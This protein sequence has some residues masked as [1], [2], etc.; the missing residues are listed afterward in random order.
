MSVIHYMGYCLVAVSLIPL[1]EGVCSIESLLDIIKMRQ[2]S[3]LNRE[4]TIYR[5][6]PSISYLCKLQS[7]FS[8]TIYFPLI[9]HIK[10]FF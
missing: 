3:I 6:H 4:I 10:V 1:G 8:K 2:I 5:Y 7:S 9:L